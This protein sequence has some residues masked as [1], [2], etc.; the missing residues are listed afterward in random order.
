MRLRILHIE[1]EW[2]VVYVVRQDLRAAQPYADVHHVAVDTLRRGLELLQQ[3]TWDVVLLDLSLPD[4]VG[5]DTFHMVHGST[6]VP[7]VVLTASVSLDERAEVVAAGAQDCLYKP[8][9]TPDVLLR[10]IRFAVERTRHVQELR[11]ALR[12]VQASC[13]ALQEVLDQREQ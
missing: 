11:S 2:G 4:C 12:E 9:L 6:D 10:S 3:E 8:E 13:R 5:L 7:I 1:D